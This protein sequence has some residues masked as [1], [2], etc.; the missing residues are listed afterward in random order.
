MCI[1]AFALR[2]LATVLQ[3]FPTDLY[4]PS[5]AVHRPVSAK[6]KVTTKRKKRTA[7]TMSELKVAVKPN[8]SN[9]SSHLTTG[10]NRAYFKQH[11]QLHKTMQLANRWCYKCTF[12]F[13][14]CT[15]C[16]QLHTKISPVC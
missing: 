16:D 7:V 4:R 5:V 12:Q 13:Y 14:T 10:D 9:V 1:S 3:E 2:S 8:T 6:P 11:L 15:N